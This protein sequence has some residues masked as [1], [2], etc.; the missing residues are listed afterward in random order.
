MGAA[1]D[2]GAPAR[3]RGAGHSKEA[4]AKRGFLDIDDASDIAALGRCYPC[5]EFEK[6]RH[7]EKSMPRAKDGYKEV[8]PKP[9]SGGNKDGPKDVGSSNLQRDLMGALGCDE[10]GALHA[11]LALQ[12][13]TLL[14]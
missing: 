7:V 13:R 2:S 5:S 4:N 8:A 11:A 1:G 9:E 14:A 12:V 3:E 10:S 6:R